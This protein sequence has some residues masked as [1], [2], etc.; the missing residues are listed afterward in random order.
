MRVAGLLL[1]LIS[2]G[3]S[4]E[5]GDSC[6]SSVDCSVNGERICDRAQPGGY[7]TVQGC[8]MD[9]C[10]DEAVCV[11]FRSEPERLASSWCMATCEENG[12][13]RDGYE[14]RTADR[15]LDSTCM[16]IAQVLDG[17]GAGS[18]FCAVPGNPPSCP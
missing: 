15:I 18:R 10:P 11:E 12:D 1:F 4:P 16:P 3:C 7:C 17:S 6:E 8:E 14:C 5:I 9:T 2:A 13:C